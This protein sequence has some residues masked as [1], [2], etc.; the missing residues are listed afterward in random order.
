MIKAV[1]FDMDGVLID[2]VELGFRVRKKLLAQYNVDLDT[3]PDPQHEGHRAASL[4]SLLTSIKDHSGVRI[5][6]D[7]FAKI[8][9]LHMRRDLEE[10]GISVDSELIEFLKDLQQHTITCA[11]VSSGQRKGVDIKLEVLG[12]RQYFSVI[13]T[14]NDVNEHKPHPAPYLYAL[15]KLKLPAS[16]TIIFEDSLTGIQAAQSANC[17]V[18][19]F[20]KY[21]PPKKQLDGVVLTIKKWSE[22]S[23]S[24]LKQY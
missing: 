14:G 22:V 3:V 19:G 16:E 15:K 5:D 13:V 21:N 9:R 11:I 10:S 1:I 4:K 23:Y 2:S 18:I 8:S 7:E 17:K 12:I 20:T 6:H 24:K